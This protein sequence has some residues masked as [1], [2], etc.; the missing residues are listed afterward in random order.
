MFKS[1][2]NYL[3]RFSITI[4]SFIVIFTTPLKQ[5]DPALYLWGTLVA[6]LLAVIVYT[7]NSVLIQRALYRRVPLIP[8]IMK[9]SHLFYWY[10]YAL[11]IFPF[12]SL[13]F[14]FASSTTL[15]SKIWL[16][17]VA[18]EIDLLR[19]IFRT[20]FEVTNPFLLMKNLSLTAQNNIDN[21]NIPKLYLNIDSSGS[22]IQFNYN[23]KSI[24]I[25]NHASIDLAEI[26]CNLIFNTERCNN[27]KTIQELSKILAKICENFENNLIVA[28]NNDLS[29]AIEIS[30]GAIRTIAET[31]FKIFPE[32]ASI[33]LGCLHRCLDR[34][35]R[36]N[37]DQFIIPSTCAILAE[38]SA[39]ILDHIDTSSEENSNLY[40]ELTLFLEYFAPRIPDSSNE[41]TTKSI[42]QKS[43]FILIDKLCEHPFIERKNLNNILRLMS[44]IIEQHLRSIYSQKDPK[45]YQ[46]LHEKLDKIEQAL[47]KHTSKP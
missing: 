21:N 37:V 12:I 36:S 24:T 16:L 15:G 31:T 33:P 43:L 20:V 25:G 23:N 8:S 46:S 42:I 30:I 22:L 14:Y 17:G 35:R 34:V 13:I 32:Y 47:P 39:Q 7:S 2:L 5:A 44:T 3:L 9:P 26:A 18:F 11:F 40:L 29:S 38:N 10:C 28:L 41:A 45:F 19:C 4:I 1:S 6:T 27:I